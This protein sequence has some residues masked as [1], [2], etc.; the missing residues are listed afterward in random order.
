M[1]T[2]EPTET[3]LLTKAEQLL[4]VYALGLLHAPGFESGK[5][6]TPMPEAG[7]ALLKKFGVDLES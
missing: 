1:N 2:P 3:F 4:I 5:R 6:L 7:I